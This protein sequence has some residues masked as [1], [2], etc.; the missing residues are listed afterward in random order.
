MVL[1]ML[2]QDACLATLLFLLLLLLEVLLLLVM[3]LSQQ[4]VQSQIVFLVTY[5]KDVLSV[6]LVITWLQEFLALRSQQQTL[7]YKQVFR[8]VM[9]GLLV[10]VLHVMMDFISLLEHVLKMLRKSLA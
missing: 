7:V 3:L 1:E 4:I 5:S 6:N 9:L 2:V 10:L 8:I